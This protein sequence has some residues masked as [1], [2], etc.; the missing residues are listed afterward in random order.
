MTHSQL[1]AVHTREGVDRLI[2]YA[3]TVGADYKEQRCSRCLWRQ[4]YKCGG[5]YV[6]GLSVRTHATYVPCVRMYMLANAVHAQHAAPLKAAP[7]LHLTV[8]AGMS[9]AQALRC[10]RAAVVGN[11][12]GHVAP[13]RLRLPRQHSSLPTRPRLGRSF[14]GSQEFDRW[15]DLRRLAAGCLTPCGLVTRGAARQCTHVL[16][17]GIGTSVTVMFLTR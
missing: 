4:H 7:Q 10:C 2:C 8:S 6:A 17:L 5:G 12:R 11:D 1:A 13:A 3:D 16:S 9:A 14:H 15:L